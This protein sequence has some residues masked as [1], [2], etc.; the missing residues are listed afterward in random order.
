MP[1]CQTIT[2]E[3]QTQDRSE[4]EITN[5]T[6]SSSNPTVGEQIQVTASVSN[7]VVEGDGETLIADIKFSGAGDQATTTV[8]VPPGGQQTPSV[9]LTMNDTGNQDICTE[10]I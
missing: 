2:V 7:T 3:E 4:L 5:T 9:D 8:E 1:V 10:I 6:T